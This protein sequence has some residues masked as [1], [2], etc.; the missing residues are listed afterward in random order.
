MKVLLFGQIGLRKKRFLEEFEDF[1]RRKGKVL[2]CFHVGKMMYEADPLIKPHRI[3]QKDIADLSTLR[4]RVWEQIITSINSDRTNAS[5]I[6]N[7]H[8]VFRWSRGLFTGFT[9]EEILKLR[10]DICVTLIDDI[11]DIKYSF[12]H[13]KHKPESFTLKDMIVWREEEILASEFAASLVDCKHYVIAKKQ[14]PD[15]LYKLIFE[16]TLKKAY[17][18]YPISLVREIPRVWSDITH[19]RQQLSNKMIC[20]DP[21]SISEGFLQ[22]EYDKANINKRRKIIDIPID[23]ERAVMRLLIDEVKEVI[24]N[25]QGQI[26]ARDFKLIDQSDMVIAYIP[27]VKGSPAISEGVERELA[28]AQKATLDTYV[29]WPSARH[30]SPFLEATRTFSR[31]EDLLNDMSHW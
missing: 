11:H 19:F 10:P 28:H 29:I 5:F 9:K 13:R 25:I 2:K 18:S 7:T 4:A 20:F 30:P 6:I 21:Y 15:L 17:L 3:L 23:S 8:S 12:Y 26:V 22:G 16:N 31:I 24:P 27:V 1:V 14:C